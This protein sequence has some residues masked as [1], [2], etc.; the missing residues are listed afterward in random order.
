M[1]T[2]VNK[3][4]VSQRKGTNKY[5]SDPKISQHMPRSRNVIQTVIFYLLMSIEASSTDT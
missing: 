2:K 3:M 5:E 1:V 4:P